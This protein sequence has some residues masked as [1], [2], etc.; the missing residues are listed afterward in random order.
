MKVKVRKHVEK[1]SDCSVLDK[2]VF[3]V[4]P[5]RHAKPINFDKMIDLLDQCD[6]LMMTYETAINSIF[7]L[8]LLS[9]SLAKMCE[10][11]TPVI[12]I[13]NFPKKCEFPAD[14]RHATIMMLLDKIRQYIIYSQSALTCHFDCY[15]FEEYG[16][17][18]KLS[19]AL[20]RVILDRFAKLHERIDAYVCNCDIQHI[21]Q[22]N[23]ISPDPEEGYKIIGRYGD[24]KVLPI[25]TELFLNKNKEDQSNGKE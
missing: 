23:I 11:I 10:E 7:D 12:F 24:K 17:R 25:L 4:L 18:E 5:D 22:L 13:Y 19:P 1:S 3:N 16:P 14:T 15:D 9:F 8:C 20:I 21:N 6:K 2:K